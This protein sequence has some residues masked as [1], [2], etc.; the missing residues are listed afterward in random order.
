MVLYSLI[1]LLVVFLSFFVNTKAFEKVNMLYNPAERETSRQLLLNEVLLFGIFTVLFLLSAFRVGIGND[2]WVYRNTFLLIAG[3]DT[4]VSYEI[5]FKALVK[6]MQALFGMDNFRVTFA[7]VAFMTVGFMLRGMYEVSDW[8][9]GSVFLY[10][11]NGFYFMSYSNVRYYLALAIVVYSMK[12][13]LS[14]KPVAFV[15]WVCFAGL[16]HMTAFVVI[17]VYLA[18]YY[19]RWNKKTLW[20]IPA[21]ITAALAGKEVIR[22]LLF[23]IY[24]YYEND[25]AYDNGRISYMNILKC[26]A[27]CLFALLYFKKYIAK[28]RKACFFFNLNL[29]ALLLYSFCSYIPEIT[30]ICYYMVIGQIFLLPYLISEMEDRKQK[31]FWLLSVGAAFVAYFYIFLEKGKGAEVLILPYITWLFT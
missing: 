21:A 5:G 9:F 24:P 13:V 27:V 4:P 28:N 29:F 18:A 20:L 31:L 22:A 15:L 17:P 16:F 7:V 14:R 1:T 26:A 25:P 19:L 30:R 6:G 23:K 10:M 8:M 3:G 12:Y 2:Y 11:A